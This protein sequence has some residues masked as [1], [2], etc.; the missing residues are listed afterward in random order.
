MENDRD[1]VLLDIARKAILEKF[2]GE[3]YINKEYLLN[4]YPFLKENRAVFVTLNKR[5]GN[6]TIPELRGCIGSI[7][8]H[9]TLLEDL[10]HNAK[11]A[12]FDDPRFPPLGFDEFDDVSI[13]ISILSIPQEVYYK[14]IDELRS[15][16]IPGKHGVIL[17]KNWNR[18]TFLPDVWMKLPDFEL[19]FAHLCKKAG[20]PDNCL[21]MYPE[22]EIYTVEKIEED[23]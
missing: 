9:R 22:I 21:V 6:K 15:I 20:L 18:A 4:K 1:L 3:S 16:I 7:L 5:K 8:P 11:A 10:I 12:A 17:K 2:T 14:D 19:F 23:K 13:E